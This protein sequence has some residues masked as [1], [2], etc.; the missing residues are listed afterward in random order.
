MFLMI[1]MPKVKTNSSQNLL[2]KLVPILLIATIVLAFVV[3]VLWQKVI[4]LEKGGEFGATAVGGGGGDSEVQPDVTSKL[5]DLPALVSS[6]GIDKTKFDACKD[7]DK[8]KKRVEDD[9]QEGIKAGVQGTPGNF[10]VNSKG[11][12]WFIPGALPYEDIKTVIELALGKSSGTTPPQKIKKLEA[13]Q[14]AKL[15]KIKSTDHVRGNRNAKVFLIEYS[16]FQC[17]YCKRFHPTAQQVLKNYAEDVAWVYRHYPLDQIHPYA[18]P[19]AVAS[20]CVTEIGGEEAFW[21]FAD[22]VFEAS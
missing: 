3:G 15:P 19:A 16:D 18:R 6:I 12:V 8:N 11:D 10:I 7:S 1:N 9:Y 20:E 14:A 21:K 13:D 22:A 2:E 17:P 4:S 5:A